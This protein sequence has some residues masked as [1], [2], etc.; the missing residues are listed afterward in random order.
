M[1]EKR[2]DIQLH[3]S[4][5][6]RILNCEDE[7]ADGGGLFAGYCRDTSGVTFSFATCGTL[8]CAVPLSGYQRSEVSHG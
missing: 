8:E 3:S 1:G 2:K 6:L 7:P 5:P 4:T